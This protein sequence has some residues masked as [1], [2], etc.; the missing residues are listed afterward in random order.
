MNISYIYIYMTHSQSWYC[1]QYV[2]IS[3]YDVVLC[4][5]YI[6]NI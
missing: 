5:S 2:C 4:V 6:Y 3:K 1:S